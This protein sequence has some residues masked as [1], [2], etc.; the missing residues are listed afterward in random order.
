MASVRFTAMAGIAVVMSTAANAADMPPL[1]PPPPMP[2]YEEFTG[3]WYLRGDIGMT[4]QQVGSLDNVLFPGTP[5]LVIRDKN[6][7]S[8][9]LAGLGFGYQFNN[10][11][12]ADVTGEYRGET[13]FHGLDT[14][15]DTFNGVARFNNYTAK[16]SEWLFLGNIYADLGT[17][18]AFTPFIGLGIGGARVTIHSFRDQGIDAFGSPTLGY[19]DA[20]SKWNFAWA[21]HA[22]LAYKVTNNVTIEFAYRY[23]NLGDGQ[24]GDIVTYDGFNTVNNPMLFKDIT[25]HDFKLGVRWLLDSGPV[26]KEPYYPPQPQPYYP[27]PLMRRG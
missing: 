1:M 3:G 24:S 5:D 25:S 13:G 9:M 11:F 26:Y 10:W 12:R 2:Y 16:K 27:P 19:A 15:F 21:I 20:A 22:G 8:G 14:W 18:N 4:N 17:W 6:F 23:V 7:E